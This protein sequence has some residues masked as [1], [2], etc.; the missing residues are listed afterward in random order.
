MYL[1]NAGRE[2]RFGRHEKKSRRQEIFPFCSLAGF[3]SLSCG[4]SKIQIFPQG[5]DIVFK[6]P[7]ALPGDAAHGARLFSG[8]SL[9][10]R[11]IS[12][13]MELVE[14]NAE[15]AGGGIGFF[16]EKNKIGLFDIHEY[17]HHGKA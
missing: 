14:L 11:D 16:F 5:F 17:R 15:I 12:G 9:F 13:R 3:P 2:K 4:W 1:V 8:K 10:D 6:C 7:A